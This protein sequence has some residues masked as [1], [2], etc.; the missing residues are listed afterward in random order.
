MVSLTML[1]SNCVA[2]LQDAVC[3]YMWAN[4][5]VM[6]QSAAVGTCG[7]ARAVPRRIG[8]GQATRRQRGVPPPIMGRNIDIAASV[9][10][11]ATPPLFAP[12]QPAS[13]ARTRDSSL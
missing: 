7:Q 4:L 12:L 8:V 1:R 10:C 2:K 9:R 13:V 3:P 5:Q 11:V 6:C